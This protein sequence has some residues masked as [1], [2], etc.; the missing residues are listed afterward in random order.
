MSRMYDES[1]NEGMCKR[2][3]EPQ[4]PNEG[5]FDLNIPDELE[6]PNEGACLRYVLSWSRQ[7]SERV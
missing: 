7:L 2:S 1:P 6:S 4:S 5:H 3:D